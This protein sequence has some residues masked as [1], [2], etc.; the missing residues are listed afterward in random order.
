MGHFAN[1]CLE[2]NT[3]LLC[4]GTIVTYFVLSLVMPILVCRSW[5]V[6]CILAAVCNKLS[7]CRAPGPLHAYLGPRNICVIVN[8][9]I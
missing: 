1:K 5:G 2:L 8:T 4:S 7:L 6:S 9:Y 3:L